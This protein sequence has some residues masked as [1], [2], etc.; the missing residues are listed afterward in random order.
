MFC[1]S[2]AGGSGS[3]YLEWQEQLEPAVEVVAIQLPG[4]GSRMHERPR[5]SLS[6]LVVQLAQ[7]I[8]GA[9]RVPFVFFGH[10][11]G[12]LLAF[13]VARYCK[14]RWLGLPRALFVSGCNPPQIP[15]TEPS[16]HELAGDALIAALAGYEGTPPELLANRPLMTLLAPAIRADFTL[17]AGYRYRPGPLLEMPIIVISGEKDGYVDLANLTAWQKETAGECRVKWFDGGHFFLNSNQASLLEFLH[18]E[19]ASLGCVGTTE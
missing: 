12:A 8:D 18:G 7:L 17:A 1:F 15:S 4:R 5:T 16:L 14:R 9:S 19:L 13:E 6:E 2:Y 10:S 11:I 3:S